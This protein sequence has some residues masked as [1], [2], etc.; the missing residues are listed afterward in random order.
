MYNFATMFLKLNVKIKNEASFH[1][2]ACENCHND[3]VIGQFQK[4]VSER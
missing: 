2:Y 3:F 4:I 1:Y